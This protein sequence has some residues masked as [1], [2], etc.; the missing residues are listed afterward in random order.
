M[1]ITTI[2]NGVH[3]ATFLLV[4]ASVLAVVT[5][6]VAFSVGVGVDD[7]KASLNI[8]TVAGFVVAEGVVVDT[9][10]VDT[11]SATIF[12]LDLSTGR[13]SLSMISDSDV[14]DSETR[15]WKSYLRTE[16]V[17]APVSGQKRVSIL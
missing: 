1:M 13:I 17:L 2:E 5:F 7:N 4:E 16:A 10:S 11:S 9:T 14:D 8:I 15:F 12:C 3:S 6:S